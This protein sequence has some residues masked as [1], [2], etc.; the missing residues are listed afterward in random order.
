M[1]K[2]HLMQTVDGLEESAIDG[3]KSM[4]E[5]GANSLDIVEIVSVS[6]RELK[7]K[8]PRSELSKLTNISGLVDLLHTVST[9]SATQ[10]A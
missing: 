4:K 10:S 7:V 5:L 6:M 2:K 3:D 1:V 9:Q 8:V